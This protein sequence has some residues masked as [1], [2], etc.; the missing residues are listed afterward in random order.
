MKIGV[1]GG[2][3]NPIHSGHIMMGLAAKERLSLEVVI[4]VPAKH[5]PHKK[6]KEL[7][8]AEDRLRMTELAAEK[9]QGFV[10]SDVE[11][12]RKETSYTINTIK[13]LQREF[14]QAEM[15]FIIGA[16]TIVELPSWKDIDELTELCR[17][18]A[19]SREGSSKKDFDCLADIFSKEKIEK[20]KKLFLEVQPIAVSATEIREKVARGESITGLVPREVEDYIIEK[21]LYKK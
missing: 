2:S 5:P 16:D 13:Q 8:K 1:L 19:I 9:Y 7:A 14:P 15:Y 3:F 4:L 18:V 10:V 17:F 11:L 12:K 6:E 21:G 20:L